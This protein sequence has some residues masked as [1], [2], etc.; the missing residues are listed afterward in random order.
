MSAGTALADSS[1]MRLGLVHAIALV[2]AV[3]GG[4][5]S[6]DNAVTDDSGELNE[7]Q[8][9]LEKQLDPPLASPTSDAI[10]AKMSDV[11]AKVSANKTESS[12]KSAGGCSTVTFRDAQTKKPAVEHVTCAS[13]EIIRVLDA[14]GR[15]TE[16]HADLNKDGKVDRYTSELAAVAQYTDLDFDGRVDVVVERVDQLKDFSMK[17]YEEVFPKSMFLYRVREDRNHDGKLDWEKLT[18][19]GQLPKTQ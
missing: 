8:G 11:I 19:R 14:N 3:L 7:G 9:V 2:G 15:P 5:A 18:A 13:S 1:R 10:G 17:G 6:E 4:C 12:P 16:E